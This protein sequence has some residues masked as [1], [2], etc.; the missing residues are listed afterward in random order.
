M[1]S[2]LELRWNL[3]ENPVRLW[4]CLSQCFGGRLNSC[5]DPSQAITEVEVFL[6]TRRDLDNMFQDYP[7]YVDRFTQHGEKQ[8]EEMK[9]LIAK[10]MSAAGESLGRYESGASL[11]SVSKR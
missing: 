5:H 11:R 3:H 7:E 6:L 1:G 8:Y 4:A 2:N 10:R 9:A